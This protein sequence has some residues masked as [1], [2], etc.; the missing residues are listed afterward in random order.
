VDGLFFSPNNILEGTESVEDSGGKAAV[1]STSKV[2]QPLE[3]DILKGGSER[4][5]YPEGQILIY[6]FLKG[7]E[8]GPGPGDRRTG[9]GYL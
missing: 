4:D 2:G 6:I 5:G 8:G 1:A 9:S 3:E 7:G